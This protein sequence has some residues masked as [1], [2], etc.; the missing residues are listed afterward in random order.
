[1]QFCVTTYE[2]MCPERECK[3]CYCGEPLAFGA[4]YMKLACDFWFVQ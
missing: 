2:Q 4:H 3:H 1:M